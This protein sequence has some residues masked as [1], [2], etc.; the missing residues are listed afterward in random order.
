MTF[1][2]EDVIALLGSRSASQEFRFRPLR[3]FSANFKSP[4][5]RLLMVPSDLSPSPNSHPRT[6][7]KVKDIGIA[8]AHLVEAKE[9]SAAGWSALAC[10]RCRYEASRR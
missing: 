10:A 5:A 3:K 9:D 8:G 2:P 7:I 4:P 6:P 1:D